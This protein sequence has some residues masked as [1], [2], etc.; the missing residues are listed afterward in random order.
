MKIRDSGM[1]QESLWVTFFDVK[2]FLEKMQINRTVQNLMEIG[3]GYGTFT[4][5]AAKAIS[6]KIYAFDIEQEMIEYTQEKAKQQGL[7]NINFFNRDIIEQGSGLAAGEV[8]Y[9]MLFNILH[10]DKP[11][12]L[13]R[14]AFNVLNRNGKLG[15][16]HW[17]TDIL[18]P[19]GP[20][21]SIRPTPENCIEWAYQTG[22][23]IIKAPEILEPYHYGLIMEKP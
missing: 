13:L 2:T 22:F 14:E 23:K 3:C 10:H 1:P 17:R 15:I 20:D 8:D 5:D 4:I 7:T 6:G 12:D 16:I 18:T 9:V 21:I 19:R 11:Q